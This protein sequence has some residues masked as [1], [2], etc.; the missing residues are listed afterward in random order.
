MKRDVVRLRWDSAES[1]YCK[2]CPILDQGE[3]TE[4]LNLP[5]K[6]LEVDYY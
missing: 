2:E 5:D 6:L 1:S 4:F 3:T